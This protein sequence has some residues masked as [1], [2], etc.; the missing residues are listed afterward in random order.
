MLSGVFAFIGTV[1]FVLDLPDVVV[2]P[3]VP[4]ASWL[5]LLALTAYAVLPA[6]YA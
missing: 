3:L 6:V 5:Y 4:P 1:R 2:A